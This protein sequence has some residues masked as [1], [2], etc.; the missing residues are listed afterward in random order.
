MPR[1][2]GDFERNDDIYDALA[3]HDKEPTLLRNL[4]EQKEEANLLKKFIEL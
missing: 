2:E 3:K 4:S 1:K